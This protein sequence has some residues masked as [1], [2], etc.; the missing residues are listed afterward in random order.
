M[1]VSL[2]LICC[3]AC[4][5]END[6]AIS[7]MLKDGSSATTTIVEDVDDIGILRL[8]PSLVPFKDH[9][10]Y[11]TGKYVD[12][13]KLIEK[14]EGSLEEFSQGEVIASSL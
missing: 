5:A 2:F 10:R 9:L 3:F 4:Q 6:F 12:Q 14:H 8:D 11:R 7:T 1:R 13:K